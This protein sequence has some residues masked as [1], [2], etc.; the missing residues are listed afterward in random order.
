MWSYNHKS[1]LSKISFLWNRYKYI[2]ISVQQNESVWGS[3]RVIPA[4]IWLLYQINCDEINPILPIKWKNLIYRY[5]HFSLEN[6]SCIVFTKL[7]L[8][9]PS[10]QHGSIYYKKFLMVF[11]QM[12]IF[13]CALI[14]N[15]VSYDSSD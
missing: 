6:I 11:P 13:G 5:M 14:C 1:T 10:L 8:I 9:T 2:R 7:L 4:K 12:E 15:I 3:K